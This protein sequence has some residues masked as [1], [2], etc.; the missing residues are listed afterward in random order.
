MHNVLTET[1]PCPFAASETGTGARCAAIQFQTHSF[2][3]LPALPFEF[4]RLPVEP[5]FSC[6]SCPFW[7]TGRAVCVAPCIRA[8][9]PSSPCC[10]PDDLSLSHCSLRVS[11]L[12]HMLCNRSAPVCSPFSSLLAVLRSVS[13][14]GS[15][16]HA[17]A[18]RVTEKGPVS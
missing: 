8:Q 13:R 4:F 7:Y 6:V 16:S 1:E 14:R 2:P 5:F 3:D 12:G 9:R 18:D 10:Q 17:N 11:A 15:Q